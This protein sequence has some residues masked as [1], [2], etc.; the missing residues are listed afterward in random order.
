[1]GTIGLRDEN[2]AKMECEVRSNVKAYPTCVE[3]DE[4]KFPPHCHGKTLEQLQLHKF[5]F[6]V[7]FLAKKDD[8]KLFKPEDALPTTIVSEEHYGLVCRIP[9]AKTGYP[10][11]IL[12][13]V[14]LNEFFDADKFYE[15]NH[16]QPR[17]ANM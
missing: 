1:M 6:D 14:D 7:A 17:D 15:I 3:Y 12:N 9:C 8:S 5:K 4:F 16:G 13:D 10:R 11:S 2:I